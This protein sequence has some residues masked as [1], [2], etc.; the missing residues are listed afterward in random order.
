MRENDKTTFPGKEIDGKSTGEDFLSDQSGLANAAQGEYHK[1]QSAKNTAI[2]FAGW[3]VPIILTFA[4]ALAGFYF[5]SIREPLIRLEERFNSLKEAVLKN[6]QDIEILKKIN[7]P[8]PP[9][10]ILRDKN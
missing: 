3:S 10:Q 5:A 8:S 4:V 6:S 1:N 7:P 9:P 2:K